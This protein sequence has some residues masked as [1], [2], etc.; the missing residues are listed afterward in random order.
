VRARVEDSYRRTTELKRR[1]VKK[2]T[3]VAENEIA[4]RL[5]ELDHRR[6]VSINFAM[7]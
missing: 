6:L 3:G 1:H 7:G 2:F 5:A 4:A